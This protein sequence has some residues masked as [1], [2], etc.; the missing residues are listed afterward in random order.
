MCHSVAA[1]VRRPCE[2]GLEGDDGGGRGA[3][4]GRLK[5]RLYSDSS[6]DGREGSLEVAAEQEGK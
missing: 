5:P 1:L 4:R 2:E 6:P 3:G